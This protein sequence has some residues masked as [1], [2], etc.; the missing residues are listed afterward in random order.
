[1]E[2]ASIGGDWCSK[3]YWIEYNGG[4]LTPFTL[5]FIHPEGRSIE[6][7]RFVNLKA[8]KLAAEFHA[9]EMAE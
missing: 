9:L 4:Q 2:W 5:L 7:G 6:M 3:S 1:M 8:A